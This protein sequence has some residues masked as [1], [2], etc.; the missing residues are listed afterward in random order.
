MR[1]LLAE[2]DEVYKCHCIQV[3]TYYSELIVLVSRE[4]VAL[5]SCETKVNGKVS[6]I[7]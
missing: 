4:H 5:T 2:L 3:D 1:L 6:M 7:N